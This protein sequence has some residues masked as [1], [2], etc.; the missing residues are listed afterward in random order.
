VA[1]IEID[2]VRLAY[3]DVTALDG[4]SVTF[5][6]G[7]NV[8]LGPNGSGKTTLFRVAAGVLPPD[9]GEATIDGTNPIA[10]PSVKTQVGYLPHGTPLNGQ[11]TVRENLEYWGRVLGLDAKT[12]AERIEETTAAMAVGGLLDRAATDL[13]RG[14]R[15]RVTITRLLLGDPGVLFLDEPTT[16][17]DPSAARALRD[18]LDSLA[19]EGRTLCYST[20]NLYEAELLADELVLIKAGRVVARGRKE[21]LIGRLNGDGAREV[22]IET[23]A[24]AEVFDRIGVEVRDVPD[25]WIV[26]LPEAQSVSDLIAALVEHGAAIEAVHEEETTLEDLYSQLT[27]D[28]EVTG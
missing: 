24:D 15:Q 20:H 1:T 8:I 18:Q 3:G 4:L 27:E 26:T 22:R 7:F 19:S 10:D 14:Q 16:G 2:D 6:P 25:G 21:E 12:R 5:D 13:S 11:L 17:L 28:E 23:G 9:S